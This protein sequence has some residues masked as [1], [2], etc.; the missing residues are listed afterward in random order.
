[1][2]HS[3]KN[4]LFICFFFLISICMLCFITISTPVIPYWTI[5][6]LVFFATIAESLSV[7]MGEKSISVSSAITICAMILYGPIAAV[8]TSFLSYVFRVYRNPDTN[9]IMTI[10]SK[11]ALTAMSNSTMTILS[12]SLSS[13]AYVALNGKILGNSIVIGSSSFSNV[14]TIISGESVHILIAITIDMLV[15]TLLFAGYIHTSGRGQLFQEWVH[16]FFWS[17]AGLLVVGLMGVLLTAIYLQYGWFV[18]LLFFA[19]LLLAR[20]TFSLYNNLRV[21]YMDTVKSLSDAIEAKDLYTR[22]HS[23]RVY[24]YSALI[25][26]CCR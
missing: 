9:K 5:I 26:L 22:G 7:V 8:W 18:A 2:K 17:F 20:Y 25:D 10:F 4:K 24:E 14:I 19:P 16:D 21:S 3:I 11:S 15:N 12:S 23:Q 6:S 13:L 1:M